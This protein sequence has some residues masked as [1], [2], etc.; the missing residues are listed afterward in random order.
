M[1]ANSPAPSSGAI[2]INKTK[3]I[4]AAICVVVGLAIFVIPPP[5]GVHPGG[6]H[7]LGVFVGTILGLILQPLPTSAVAIIGLTVAMLT[8]AMDPSKEAFSGLGSASIW[9]IVA[10]F[11]IAQGF[12]ST[13]LGRRIALVF[14][15]WLGK[16]S[17]GIS[18]GLAAADLVLAPATP[19]N[20]ARLGGI[21]FP[22]IQS[23]SEV[24]G[25]TTESEESRK[26][27]GGFLSATANNVNAI[28][29]A[30]FA[31]S[32]AA[33]PVVI[34]LAS[35]MHHPIGWGTWAIACIV[36]GL[37]CLI[38]IPVLIYKIF[39]P[40]IKHVP[41]ART[42]AKAELKA[43]GSLSP[44]EWVMALSFVLMLILWATGS[45]TGISA[46][47]VAFLGVTILLC[48]GII[49]WKSMANDKSA[50]STLIFFGVLVGM[51]KP[52]STLGVT[53]WLGG[54]IAHM[55]G[56]MPWYAVLFI[57]G[58]C[59]VLVHYLFA[60]ELAQV[61]ALY[62]LFV[63]VTIAAGA[64][65]PVAVLTFGALSGLIGAMTHYAS[66]PSA[67]IYGADYLKTSEFLRVGIICAMVTTVIFLTVGVGWWKVIG[68]W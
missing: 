10:A 20:T 68:L 9:L 37:L 39:P 31:T 67:L 42:D 2:A 8:G 52:L 64:P 29:S 14:I 36:P 38:L 66:G 41:T 57:L 35:Q 34:Q 21:L 25:S 11:F 62:T 3:I 6:M 4:K 43:M 24:Q 5:Q 54:L 27:L 23:I 51:A 28:T 7:M 60:S 44:K 61:V 18:Y 56:G 16:S 33:G 32:M 17:L 50:W 65:A 26:K 30:M 53:D 49:T 19:S 15:S 46:T 1:A 47:T 22:I 48:T 12:V 13:G 58:I 55:V 45:M 40:T 59:Y 63:T